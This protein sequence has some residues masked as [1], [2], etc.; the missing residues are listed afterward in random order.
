METF[1]RTAASVMR[2]SE[3]ARRT[4]N[5]LLLLLGRPDRTCSCACAA[6][7]AFIGIDHIFAVFLGNRAYRTF[8]RTS[9]ASDTF[10][11]V[12]DIRHTDSP[13]RGSNFFC[14]ICVCSCRQ[15]HCFFIVSYFVQM[16]N[17]FFGI[18]EKNSINKS[19][20]TRKNIS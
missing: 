20:H 1:F 10:F 15:T 11:G 4:R 12:N 14:S 2:R 7:D 9:A 18:F 8:V 17:P 6:I 13:F 16:S 5:R 3:P 19:K